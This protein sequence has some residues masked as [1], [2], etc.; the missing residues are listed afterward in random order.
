VGALLAGAI[1]TWLGW[2]SESVQTR[3]VT[4]ATPARTVTVTRTVARTV[5]KPDRRAGK[6][7]FVNTCAGCH[8][9]RRENRGDKVNLAELEPSY[10]VI[11]DKVKRGGIAMPPLGRRLSDDQIRDVAAYVAAA[12]KR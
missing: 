3:T 7:V 2:S 10:D 8:T 12:T 9:L 5:R 4:V 1:G 6:R 11:V